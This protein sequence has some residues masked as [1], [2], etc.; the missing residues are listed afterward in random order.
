MN[1][2]I[3]RFRIL[4]NVPIFLNS[5]TPFKINLSVSGKESISSKQLKIIR[6]ENFKKRF[7]KQIY[8]INY[9]ITQETRFEKK[10]NYEAFA[11]KI[12]Q[13]FQSFIDTNELGFFLKKHNFLIS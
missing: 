1:K 6:N 3:S 2:L 10:I 4:I 5:S 13:N 11:K 8:E 7:V 9:L 12:D